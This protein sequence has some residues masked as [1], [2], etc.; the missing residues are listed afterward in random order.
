MLA[1]LG[2]LAI[3]AWHIGRSA[4]PA[5]PDTLARAYARLCRKLERIG[6][7]RAPHQG[8][9]SFAETVSARRPD[10]RESV[11]ALL[12]RYAQLRYGPASPGAR[13][14]DVEEFRRAVARLSLARAVSR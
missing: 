5:S 9:L 2:W 10:L 12:A 4:R 8:P 1:L 13:A 11:H 7:P 6:P 3:I 14:Q